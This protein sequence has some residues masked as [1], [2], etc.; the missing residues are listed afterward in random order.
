MSDLIVIA[1]DD[2]HQAEEMRMKLVKMQNEY[3]IDMEDAVCATKDGD[4]KVKLHQ[5]INLTAF[6]ALQ[7][8]LLG[9]LV[10]MLLLNP[11]FG[12]AI[13]GAAGALSGATTDLGINDDFMKELAATL[14]P[15][16][17]AL[18]IL[19]RKVTM[20]K[21]LPQL[22]GTGGKIIKTSLPNMDEDKLQATLDKHRM[23]YSTAPTV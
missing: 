15:N 16:S 10:G 17:S 23:E 12:M 7:G 6:G 20:D 9:G 14:K 2:I 5:A 4:G 22:E 11:L 13:G 21:V 1:Y 19:V 3:L 8:S 18:F